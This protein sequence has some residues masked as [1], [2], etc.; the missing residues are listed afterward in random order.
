M[1]RS[2]GVPE[3]HCGDGETRCKMTWRQGCSKPRHQ[4]KVIIQDLLTRNR[5]TI[6]E[7]KSK[8][9]YPPK[10][11]VDGDDTQNFI[12]RK[13]KPSEVLELDASASHS[14]NGGEL[15]FKWFQYKEIDSVFPLVCP[16]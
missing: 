5:W 4:L 9:Q 3:Q 8:L 2:S 10:V 1:A 15:T 12:Y 14:P 6:E 11:I 7:D 16:I 13:V